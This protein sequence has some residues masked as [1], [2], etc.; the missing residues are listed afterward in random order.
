MRST[1]GRGRTTG[2][3]PLVRRALFPDGAGPAMTL[4]V[5]LFENTPDE[6]FI[7]D[8]HPDAPGVV[9]LGGGSGHGFKFCSVLG[10][11]AADL[12]LDGQTRHDIGLLRLGRFGQIDG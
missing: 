8:L 9:C 12:A 6:H 5:C 1:A 3:A 11:I 4:K 10:E 7:V 2:R